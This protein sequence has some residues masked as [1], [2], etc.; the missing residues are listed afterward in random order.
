MSSLRL[1]SLMIFWGGL[2]DGAELAD[3]SGFGVEDYVG[4]LFFVGEEVGLESERDA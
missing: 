1:L 4:G 3:G 2:S